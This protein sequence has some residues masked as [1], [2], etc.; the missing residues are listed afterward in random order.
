MRCQL[1]F[2]GEGKMKILC[3]IDSLGSGGAQRQ[4]TTLAVGLKSLDHEVRFLVYHQDDHFRACLDAAQIA[5]HAVSPCSAWRRPLIVRRAL[6]DGWQDVVIAFLEGPAFYAEVASLPR[7]SWGLVVGERLAD[8]TLASGRGWWLRQC[9][10]LAD[11]VVTNSHTNRLLLERAFPRLKDKLATVYNAVDLER[12]QPSIQK[13]A[14]GDG[15][16]PFRVVV[17]ASYQEKKN[18]ETVAKALLL[19]R[20][21]RQA[22]S[23]LVD[24][25]GGMPADPGAYRRACRFVEE[26]GL[27][28]TL[29]FH[30]ATQSIA[31]EFSDASAIGLFSHYEGLPNAVCEGMACGKPI[32][33]TDVCDARHLVE[34]GKN[35]F[36]CDPR[37]PASIA[38]ALRR[39]ASLTTGERQ[40]MGLESRRRAEQLFD[41]DLFLGRYER[42]LASASRRVPV[43]VD[44]AEPLEKSSSTQAAGG[45]FFQRSAPVSLTEVVKQ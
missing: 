42:I 17:A 7:R 29:N 8:P 14:S 6:R 5:C 35:G 41:E 9:H 22:P 39:M 31:A 45:S 12:F 27:C 11:A 38:E 32:V 3:L 1:E 24:W 21:E 44:Y 16:S 36:L 40:Q 30:P 13:P 4:L 34:E 23:I 37:S 20:M 19:L 33:M 43:P 28:G 26:N 25:F 2:A 15:R 18:M 10:Q